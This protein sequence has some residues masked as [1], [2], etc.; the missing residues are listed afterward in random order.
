MKNK[1]HI[2]VVPTPLIVA[3]INIA[4]KYLPLLFAKSKNQQL[5]SLINEETANLQTIVNQLLENFSF[6]KAHFQPL[7]DETIRQREAARGKGKNPHEYDLNCLYRAVIQ[8][9]TPFMPELK[10]L[11]F[12]NNVNPK[13]A[14]VE[15]NKAKDFS[16]Y[17]TT[18]V[19][20]QNTANNADISNDN[21]TAA[22]VSFKPNALAYL[23]GGYLLY[24]LFKT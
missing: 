22:S 14:C 12:L 6:L 13:W 9:A 18:L 2:G 15:W 16:Q 11:Q 21:F 4:A 20:S 24:N 23:V 8:S 17:L 19:T 7:I 10:Q 1:S 3:G 5:I